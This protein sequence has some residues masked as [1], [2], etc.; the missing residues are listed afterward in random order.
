VHQVR[1][2]YPTVHIVA[3]AEGI[4]HLKMLHDHGVY[5]A[6]QPEFEAGLEMTRQALLHLRV[7]ATDIQRF[8]DAVRR[9]L[10]AP[11][12]HTRVAY[13][14]MT[15]LQ[16]ATHLLELLWVPLPP[17]SPLIGQTIQELGIRSKTG[18]SVVGVMRHG[19]LHVNPDISYCFTSQ[20]VVAVI[21]QAEQ[22]AAFQA[23]AGCAPEVGG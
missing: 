1:R 15:Q 4:E 9:E 22:L 16:T 14:A 3:R 5:E 19:T 11:L 18:A 8:T 10:Y 23:F 21:G 13:Q 12:Y 7:S 2:H 20:D 6:V 17:E